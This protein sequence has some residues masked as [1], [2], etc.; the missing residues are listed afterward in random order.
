MTLLTDRNNWLLGAALAALLASV[1]AR[2]I[3]GAAEAQAPD[4]ATAGAVALTPEQEEA[5]AVKGEELTEKVCTECHPFDDI[6]VMRRTAREWKDVVSLMSTKG[7][8]ATQDQFAMVR[9]YLTRYYG[10]LR[11]NL[12]TPDEFQ[13]VLGLSAADAAAIVAHRDAKGKFTDLASLLAVPGID[14]A[15]VEADPDA[16]KFN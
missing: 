8:I 13:A 4:A 5:I 3:L 14:K 1:G 7:A 2:G 12:A 16:F 11:V 6:V 10:V 9:Q 15:R